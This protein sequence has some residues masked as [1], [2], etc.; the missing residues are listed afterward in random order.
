VVDLEQLS[1]DFYFN[2]GCQS[3]DKRRLDSGLVDVKS[4]ILI[5]S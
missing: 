4:D 1:C 2:I 5:K 3:K